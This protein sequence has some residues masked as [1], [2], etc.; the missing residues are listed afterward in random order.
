MRV[1]SCIRDGI[2]IT[3][4]KYV[5][6]KAIWSTSRIIYNGDFIFKYECIHDSKQKS[7]VLTFV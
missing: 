5:L 4:L 3:N 7:N 1:L 2:N 6:H